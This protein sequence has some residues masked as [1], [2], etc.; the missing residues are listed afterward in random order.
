[1][2]AKMDC[3]SFKTECINSPRLTTLFDKFAD[4]ASGNDGYPYKRIPQPNQCYID[5]NKEL[6]RF[7]IQHKNLWGKF[8]PHFF[9][10]IP[11]IL[12]AECNLGNAILKYQSVCNKSDFTLYTIGTAEATMARTIGKL[13]I[14][15]IKTLSCSPNI[16]NKTSFYSHGIP[17]DSYFHLGGFHEITNHSLRT[18]EFFKNG[19]DIIIED[20]TF[21]MYSKNRKKQINHVFNVLKNNG[22]FVIIEKMMHK[23]KN[24]YQE[25]EARKDMFKKQFFL[26]D[27]IKKKYEI[28][29]IMEQYQVTLEEAIEALKAQFSNVSIFWNSGNFYSLA[30]SNSEKNLTTFI[31]SM[32]PIFCPQEYRQILLPRYHRI[33]KE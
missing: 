22:I 23:N 13:A 1:M 4:I 25:M 29:D 33:I 18:S 31:N 11:Y 27:Q 3:L 16:E 12:E 20:T 14:G 2:E 19:F 17:S 9:A 28:L 26:D 10:S 6:S 32:S 21:Q 7:Y 5:S 30:A 15:K 24:K 8:D